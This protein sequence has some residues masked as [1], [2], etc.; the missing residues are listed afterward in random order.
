MFRGPRGHANVKV[1]ALLHFQKMTENNEA[2][3]SDLGYF[4]AA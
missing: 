4:R 3:R 1:S 2:Q